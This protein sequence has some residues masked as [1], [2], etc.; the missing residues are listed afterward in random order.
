ML[1]TGTA[2]LSWLPAWWAPRAHLSAGGTTS[3]EEREGG[4]QPRAGSSARRPAHTTTLRAG[5]DA[6][7]RQ[8]EHSASNTSRSGKAAHGR[9]VAR[10]LEAAFV[11]HTMASPEPPQWLREGAR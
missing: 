4:D 3:S 1:S 5:P 6:P 2:A 9:V 7:K 11:P 8:G 10:P